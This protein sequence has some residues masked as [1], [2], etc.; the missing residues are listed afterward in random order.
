MNLTPAKRRLLSVMLKTEGAPDE[1][2]SRAML[3]VDPNGVC[4]M[5]LQNHKM[6]APPGVLTKAG[7]ALAVE[8]SA[9]AP[10]AAQEGGDA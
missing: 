9:L 4:Y 8:I 3:K 7:R 6:V 2:R 10:P 5:S 1:A